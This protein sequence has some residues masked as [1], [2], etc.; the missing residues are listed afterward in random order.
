MVTQVSNSI[1]GEKGPECGRSIAGAMR[2]FSGLNA[3]SRAQSRDAKVG[4]VAR[5][6]SNIINLVASK[7]VVN[8]ASC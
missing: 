7:L 5:Q 1:E 2:T 3:G 8:V 4:A 6:N